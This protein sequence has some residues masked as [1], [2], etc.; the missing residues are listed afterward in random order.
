M[1]DEA[2]VEL[3]A[4]ALRLA[5]SPLVGGS[6]SAF[7]WLGGEM[8]LPILRQSH[9]PLE[10]VLDAACFPLVPYVNRI[11]GGCFSFRGRE[12]RIAPNM[13]SDSSPLHGQGWLNP[14]RV[15]QASDTRVTLAFHHE[16]DE[17]PWD[18]QARQH[19]DLDARG[20]SAEISCR[21]L[22][23]DPMPC[24]LG[25]HPYFPCDPATRL[26]T[27]VTSA[28]TI[29]DK[30]L[31]VEQVPADGRYDLRNRIV[32]GQDLDNGFGGWDGEARMSD[33]D[34]PYSLRMTSLE[35]RFFQLYSPASGGLFVAEPVSH[36]NAALNEPEEQWPALGLRVLEPGEEMS[37]SMRLD[38]IPA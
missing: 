32:C 35:S 6:I 30:V 37:L 28:W 21:N 18:Y 27:T 15:E 31:P 17:W 9:S 12:V 20:L 4:G 33:P 14:W 16:A 22:S 11:R 29:D 19:F 3:R 36:A 13:P 1:V 34:W 23:V 24:G 8:P 38:V 10:N 5:L 7:D 25:F 2:L 26:Y